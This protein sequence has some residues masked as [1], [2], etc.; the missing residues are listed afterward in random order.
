V[1]QDEILTHDILF[2][3]QEVQ[4]IVTAI[5]SGGLPKTWKTR[6]EHVSALKNRFDC[7]I[8]C[9]KCDSELILRTVKSGTNAGLQF[10]G[11]SKYS[12]CRYTKAV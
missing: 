5:K 2:S 11:C 8:I 6:R 7:T 4:D 12:A 10:Y 9:T 3:S 1:N